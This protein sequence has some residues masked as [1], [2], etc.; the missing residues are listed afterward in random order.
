M[1]SQLALHRLKTRVE[2]TFT[3]QALIYLQNSQ[4]TVT[5]KVRIEE[6]GT[7]TV[8]EATGAHALVTS[9]VRNAVGNWKFTPA[10]DEK[11]PRCVD[12]DLP[13]VISRK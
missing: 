5:V 2:P 12:T 6:N 10:M 13:I 1:E 9:S 8:L 7:V 4:V 3:P 11:G